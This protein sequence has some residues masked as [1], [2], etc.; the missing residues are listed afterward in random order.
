MNIRCIIS[1]NLVTSLIQDV[2]DPAVRK[3]LY[4]FM[5]MIKD[6]SQAVWVST[7][8]L[9]C[10]QKDCVDIGTFVQCNYDPPGRTTPLV[11]CSDALTE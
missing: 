5:L 10:S 2:R 11:L 1:L 9:G 6:F 7:H 4:I 8:T 3:M